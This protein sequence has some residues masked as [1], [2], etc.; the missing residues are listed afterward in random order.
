MGRLLLKGA[1]KDFAD[2]V[3]FPAVAFVLLKNFARRNFLHDP[4]CFSRLNR[5]KSALINFV[6][7]LNTKKKGQ[8]KELL[9]QK[10]LEKEGW[11]VIFRSY[12]IKMGPIWRGIDMAD[13]YDLVAISDRA[14]RFISIKHYSSAQTKYP[15][16]QQQIKEFAYRHG[17]DGMIFELWLW[18]KPA[19]RGRGESKHWEEAHFERIRIV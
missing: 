3:Q 12:T 11:R 5:Y 13:L 4:N 6:V 8:R 1:S 10:E 7:A 15:E 18:H 19:W 14:W 2:R 17:L 9:A 16:H